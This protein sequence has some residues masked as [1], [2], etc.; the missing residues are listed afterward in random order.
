M[1]SIN[2]FILFLKNPEL[3]TINEIKGIPDFFKLVWKSFFILILLDLVTGIIITLPLRY[4]NLLPSLK[5]LRFDTFNILKVTLLLPII[6]E[7]IFRLPLRISKINFALSFSLIIFIL[8]KGLNIMNVFIALSSSIILF[9]FLPYFI[10]RWTALNTTLVHIFTVHFRNIFYLQAVLFGSLHL[11]NFNIE[12]K[13]FYIFPLIVI[14][15]VLTGC[16][17][18]YIRVRFSNGIFLCIASH[19][20]LNSIYYMVLHN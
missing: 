16:F 10:Q 19:I 6:E 15:Y 1:V 13:Y 20:F 3:K 2:D 12:F 8:I 5:E 9:L 17:L 14:N 4:F 7:S 18:G 11:A